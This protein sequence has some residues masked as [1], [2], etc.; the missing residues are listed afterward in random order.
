MVNTHLFVS[1][2]QTSPNG[3]KKLCECVKPMIRTLSEQPCT[4]GATTT[5]PLVGHGERHFCFSFKWMQFSKGSKWMQAS[6]GL[7]CRPSRKRSAHQQRSYTIDTKFWGDPGVANFK[8]RGANYLKVPSNLTLPCAHAPS[9]Q[10]LF[11]TALASVSAARSSIVG[12]ACQRLL[13]L[14][15]KIAD[16]VY[17]QHVTTWIVLI[18]W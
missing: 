10:H 3:T 11:L 13:L 18:S 7:W 4:T 16:T 14:L 1:V 12:V 8:V 15:F 5:T 6:L 9:W 2:K 17:Q